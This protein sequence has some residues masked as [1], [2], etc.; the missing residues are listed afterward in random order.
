M[1]KT[2]FTACLVLVLSIL[3]FSQK[4]KKSP[5]AADV[6]ENRPA[7]SSKNTKN[8]GGQT[9][10]GSLLSAGTLLEAQLQSTLDVRK[11]QPGDQVVLKTVKAIKQNGQTIVPKGTSLIG[12]VTEVQQRT[13]DNA[14][15]KIGLIFDRLQGQDLAA[16]LTASVVSI[17]NIQA[18]A[19]AADDMFTTNASGSSSTSGNAGAS[20]GG[21]LGGVG[22]T[23]GGATNAVGGLTNT[24]GGVTNTATQTL[25]TATNTVGNT[26]GNTAGGLTRTVNGLQ[27][28]NS[29]SGSAQGSTTL[30]SPNKNVKVEKGAT[31]NLQ[32][33]N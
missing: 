11:S 28:S 6:P 18:T 2:L 32:V 19:A 16:P 33:S 29:I 26:V 3:G 15:S 17:T 31:F 8:S 4:Q 12:R 7:K 23:L 27:I 20:S 14:G 5:E 25:G 24:V 21:L 9:S 30:S 10:D 13:R 22:N 1:N